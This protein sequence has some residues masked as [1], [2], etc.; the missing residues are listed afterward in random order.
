VLPPCSHVF[1]HPA[2]AGVATGDRM[3]THGMSIIEF[4]TNGTR[5]DAAQALAGR[6]S[7]HARHRR[8]RGY[9]AFA[10][11]LTLIA[12]PAFAGCGGGIYDS[13]RSCQEEQVERYFTRFFTDAKSRGGITLAS[14]TSDCTKILMYGSPEQNPDEGTVR[15]TETAR[16]FLDNCALTKGLARKP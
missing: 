5:L 11:G 14:V 13:V 15:F 3:S 4:G 12:S 10:L 1:N 6:S 16:R 7:K 2:P 8:S 9:A